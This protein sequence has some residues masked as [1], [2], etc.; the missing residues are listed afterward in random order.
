MPAVKK[1]KNQT[2]RSYDHIM[3]SCVEFPFVSNWFINHHSHHHCS[4][5]QHR[6]EVGSFCISKFCIYSAWMLVLAM[7]LI[8]L[9]LT[10][11]PNIF[12]HIAVFVRPQYR[13]L[14]AWFEAKN[15]NTLVCMFLVPIY[16]KNHPTRCCLIQPR[17]PVRHELISIIAAS[18]W[19]IH[20]GVCASAYAVR[21]AYTKR[22]MA[23]NVYTAQC[24]TIWCAMLRSTA[25]HHWFIGKNK[26]KNKKKTNRPELTCTHTRP[27]DTSRA[28]GTWACDRMVMCVCVMRWCILT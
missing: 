2:L 15:I 21:V 6:N 13:P 4:Q 28:G 8:G 9:R 27:S 25:I 5:R 26:N 17:K 11:A 1:K 12:I 23:H 7:M 20:D 24:L 19:T 22:P 10:Y 16:K 18:V 3:N 14:F